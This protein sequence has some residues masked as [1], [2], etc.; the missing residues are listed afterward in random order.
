MPLGKTTCCHPKGHRVIKIRTHTSVPPNA[1]GTEQKG[2]GL[3]SARG[4]AF[5][6]AFLYP[7]HQVLRLWSWTASHKFGWK[8]VEQTQEESLTSQNE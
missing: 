6:A 2:R 8:E 4:R 5:L 1:Y 7:N 3:L